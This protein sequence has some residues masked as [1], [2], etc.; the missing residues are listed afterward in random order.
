MV[1]ADV[2]GHSKEDLEGSLEVTMILSFIVFPVGAVVRK[3]AWLRRDLC[4]DQQSI[5]LRYIYIF[6]TFSF[7]T[8]ILLPYYY[9][10]FM[11]AC[12]QVGRQ[13]DYNKKE[14]KKMKSKK[15]FDE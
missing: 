2:L 4:V 13:V 9:Y 6:F 5:T 12:Q 11:E 7:H 1:V 15:V 10:L 3:N 8:K 14:A